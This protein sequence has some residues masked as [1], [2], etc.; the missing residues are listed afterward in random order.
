MGVARDGARISALYGDAYYEGE[1]DP[2]VGYSE[3]SRTAEH[4]LAWAAA[5]IRLLSK[6]GRILDIGSVDGHLLRK[7]PE[8]ELFG[9]EVNERM[10]ER[11]RSNGV[12]VIARDI[13]ILGSSKSTPTRSRSFARLPS[14]ST[15]RTSSAQSRSP[16]LCSQT[17]AFSSSRCR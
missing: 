14:S 16:S 3:Y 2:E 10:A 13:T 6:P 8:Y 12:D 15:W 5:L 9:I 1:P 17:T 11:S 7:L 4:S